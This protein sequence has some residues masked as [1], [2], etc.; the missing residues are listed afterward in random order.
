MN[1]RAAH[2]LED[3]LRLPAEER[4]AVAAALIDSLENT[5][6]TAISEGWRTELMR[7][8]DDH[9]AGRVTAQPWASVK[10]RLGSL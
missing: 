5:D 7:R 8:R 3:V 2:L 1:A 6:E 4:S 9:R 10:A